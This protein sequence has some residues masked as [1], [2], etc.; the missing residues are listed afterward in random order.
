M[1]TR[2]LGKQGTERSQWVVLT[3]EIRHY[4]QE[5]HNADNSQ[6]NKIASYAPF[7]EWGP[8]PQMWSVSQGVKGWREIG[9]R[10]KSRS[11]FIFGHFSVQVLISPVE[12]NACHLIG[13]QWIDSC[14]FIYWLSLNQWD[15]GSLQKEKNTNQTYLL[16]LRHSSLGIEI[17]VSLEHKARWCKC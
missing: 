10:R 2:G 17:N 15:C 8:S 9:V 4:N 5:I 1:G 6:F 11:Y 3:T 14:W 13:T 7:A 16:T 12:H